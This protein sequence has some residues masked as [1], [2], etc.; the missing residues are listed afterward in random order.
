MSETQEEQEETLSVED[1]LEVLAD[2]HVIIG[3]KQAE[4]ICSVLGTSF[5]PLLTMAWENAEQ[6]R[7]KYGFFLVREGA[8]TGVDVLDLSYSVAK[9]L[10]LGAPGSAFTGKGFQA[11]ANS[12]AIARFLKS[13]E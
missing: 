2:G 1:V 5:D 13:N 4:R 12:E 11:R 6:A 9:R 3:V 7:Q 8:G 10:G